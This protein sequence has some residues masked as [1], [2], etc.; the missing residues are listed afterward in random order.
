MFPLYSMQQSASLLLTCFE[1][2]RRDVVVWR[3][4]QNADSRKKNNPE[5]VLSEA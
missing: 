1:Y 5:V 2:I 4:L 3:T